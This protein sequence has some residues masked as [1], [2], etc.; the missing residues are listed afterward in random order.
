MVACLGVFCPPGRVCKAGSPGG[1]VCVLS[2]GPEEISLP[3]WAVPAIVGS[4]ATVLALLVLSLIL[5]NQCRGKKAKNPKEEKNPKAEE[6]NV[7]RD[8]KSTRLN[9]SH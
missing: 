4:C 6:R 7:H 8:R 9:S 1:H 5:C 2:Q 3:L